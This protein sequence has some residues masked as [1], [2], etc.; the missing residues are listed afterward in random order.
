MPERG[1]IEGTFRTALNLA[2]AI[3][4]GIVHGLSRRGGAVDN[5]ITENRDRVREVVGI[6]VIGALV[7]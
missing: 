5:Y 4:V 7:L 2:G 3:P 6:G 1:I